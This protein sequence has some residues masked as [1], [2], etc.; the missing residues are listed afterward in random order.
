MRVKKPKVGV[1]ELT[2]CAGEQLAIINCE[3]ELLDIVGAID[4]RM[5]RTVTSL[6]DETGPL[7][8]AIVEGSVVTEKEIEALKAVR[9]RSA[10]LLAAG[11]CAV[12]GGI[13][14]S[15]NGAPRGKLIDAVYGTTPPSFRSIPP[16]PVKNFVTVD[17]SL[18]GCPMEKDQFLQAMSSLLHGDLPQLAT[19]PVCAECKMRENR[20]LLTEKKDVC[21]GPI[22][23]GGC[24]ARCP[25][26]EIPCI[27]CRGMVGEA[28]IAEEVDILKQM[29]HGNEFVW[30]KVSTFE[31]PPEEIRRLLRTR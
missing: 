13:P 4:I 27:G 11:T 5:F 24:K 22:T 18:P 1:L 26:L 9:A 15:S 12:Y 8:I 31:Y 21:L 6:N 20:C 25:S 16:Q 19:S 23:L 17:F 2:G 30:Q 14:S 10:L 3:D 29:G 7:D 28:N